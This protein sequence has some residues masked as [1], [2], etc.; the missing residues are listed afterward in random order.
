MPSFDLLI[1]FSPDFLFTAE[2]MPS[3]SS[4]IYRERGI[5]C[6]F[7]NHDGY[8]IY[9]FRDQSLMAEESNNFISLISERKRN[10]NQYEGSSEMFGKRSILSNIRDSP[11]PYT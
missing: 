2:N 11:N 9:V 8:R 6:G 3:V 1:Q 5:L 4:F 7:T 10:Q